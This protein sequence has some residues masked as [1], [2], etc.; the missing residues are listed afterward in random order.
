MTKRWSEGPSARLQVLFEGLGRQEKSVAREILR[1]YPL[2][3]LNT[4]AALAEQSGASTATVLR[5]VQRLGYGAYGA[6]QEAVK[7]DLN[8]MLQSPSDRLAAP[9]RV[10][11]DDGAAFVTRMFE[12]T[13]RSLAGCVDPV[14]EADFR[15]VVELL[16]DPKRSLYC[17]GGRYGRHLAGLQADYLGVLRAGV[18]LA[19]GQ[20]DGWS[21]L[22]IDIGP[23]AV[24]LVID[25]R[26]YQRTVRRFAELAKQRGAT[27][28][29]ITDLWAAA[30]DYAADFTFR[31]PTSSPSLMDSYAAPLV[32]VEALVG[33][34][35]VQLGTELHD[36]LA[37]CEAMDCVESD[38][39]L[40]WPGIDPNDANE[41][42]DT[43]RE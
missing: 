28:V 43:N 17:I 7:E 15:Q 10:G 1:D 8:R 41:T 22:L 16:A 2:S 30:R 26:R 32:L 33:A 6:F 3:A 27:V 11:E 18:Q 29:L 24:V 5:L 23:R 25:I 35:A 19:D 14:M 31:L 21:R 39:S 20:P 12:R 13:G 40:A 9:Q 36:R 37:L 34:V 4:V 42:T 38:L